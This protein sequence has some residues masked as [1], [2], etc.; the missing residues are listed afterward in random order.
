MYDIRRPHMKLRPIV[1]G[2]VTWWI[3]NLLST[4]VNPRT[5]ILMVLF[6]H[7]PSNFSSD[8]IIDARD[9]RSPRASTAIG[10]IDICKLM[11]SILRAPRWISQSWLQH[12]QERDQPKIDDQRFQ[13]YNPARFMK[14]IF[15]DRHWSEISRQQIS[16][17][18]LLISDRSAHLSITKN[19][20]I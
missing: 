20:Q 19:R 8:W 11:P 2:W 16:R 7:R 17:R 13:T 12:M 14:Q 9:T 4:T 1:A 5:M 10:F 6:D 18:I 15:S 3:L